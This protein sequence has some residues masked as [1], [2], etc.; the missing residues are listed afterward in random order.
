[1]SEHLWSWKSRATFPSL[2]GAHQSHMQDILDTLKRLGWE[3]RD[4]FGIHLALEESLTNAIKHGNRLNESK[5]VVVDCKASADRFWLRVRDEGCG[6]EP[7]EVPDCTADE[8]LECPGGRGLALIKAYMTRVEH[9]KR[10][11]CVT[12][13]KIR[14]VT[15]AGPPSCRSCERDE[16][17]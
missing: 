8:N 16:S 10:G 6:F 1:M 9:N 11:N 3:G 15:P 7:G 5:R 2:A 14:S 17:P 13:E 4:L 12:M